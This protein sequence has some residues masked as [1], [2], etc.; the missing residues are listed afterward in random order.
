MIYLLKI[1]S[2][3]EVLV[4]QNQKVPSK[5]TGVE[6]SLEDIVKVKPANG[7]PKQVKDVQ[8]ASN[9]READEDE[10]DQVTFVGRV[11]RHSC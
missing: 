9:G 8:G 3:E 10:E 5:E 1:T 11:V 2:V 6:Q 7:S 4:L